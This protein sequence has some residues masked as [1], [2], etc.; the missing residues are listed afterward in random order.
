MEP[1]ATSLE[2]VLAEL[3]R[4]DLMLRFQVWRARQLKQGGDDRF[5]GLY[6]SEQEVDALLEPSSFL[7]RWATAP[8][9]E[10]AQR[11]RRALAELRVS[12]DARVA[13]SEASGVR[14]RLRELGQRFGLDELELDILLVCLAPELSLRYERLFAYLQDDVTRRR[15]SVDLVLN[16][17]CPSLE[18]KLE[19]RSRFSAQAPLVRHLLLETFEEPSRPMASLLGRGLRVSE[20]ITGFL[21]GSDELDATL[22]AYVRPVRLPPGPELHLEESLAHRLEQLVAGPLEPGLIVH[23]LGPA[24]VGKGRWIDALCARKG[25]RLITLSGNELLAAGASVFADVLRRAMR[26]ARLPGT[27][28]CWHGFDGLLADEHRSRR[29]A[30]VREL[31]TLPGPSFLTGTTPWEPGLEGPPAFLAVEFPPPGYAARLQ[32]WT[33]ALEGALS[34]EAAGE[35][36]VVAGQFRFTAGDIR[37]A[38]M[39]ARGRARW[40]QGAPGP[41]SPEELFAASR[42]RSNSRLS[43]LASRVRRVY[44]WDDIVLPADAV[45]QLRELC[46][47]A[48]HRARVLE[49]WGF[50]RK[51]SLG[52]GVAA[53]FSGPSGTG[54]TM[55]AEILAGELGLEL[56]KVD[57]SRVIS[58]YIGETEKSLS[59]IFTE[60]ETSNAILFFDEADALF[61]KRSEVKDAHDRYANVETGYLL[62]RMEEYQGITILATNLRRNMDDAFL[63][64]LAFAISFPFPE[65]TERLRIWRGVWPTEVPRGELDLE[66]MARQFKLAGGNIKN[67]AVAAAFLA[68][69]RDEPVGM[70]HL[71]GA[72]RRE[73]QKQGR[74]CVPADFGPYAHLLITA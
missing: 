24:G 34:P 3:E 56:Y 36:P 64:R 32:L 39:A 15:P 62:Q 5:E 73:F 74:T 48:R 20:R 50:D 52:K 65:E 31:A 27:A 63:R 18:A 46:A 7:P 21:L 68:A 41:V 26:E 35:L 45:S 13:R 58:K 17:L 70:A 6:V 2:H 49:Q 61:G 14:L 54:K 60:A 10:E 25:L 37:A 66:F 1:F 16:L 12:L 40:R 69:D 33:R 30:L 11:V 55:A 67:I 72:T 19:A 22:A 71:I 44:A 57:L 53:V 4:I 28:L 47:Q 9:T 42:A 38:S 59:R 29:E 8:L 51:L 23:C 43:E